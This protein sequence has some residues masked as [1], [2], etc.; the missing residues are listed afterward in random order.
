MV[1][2]IRFDEEKNQLLK[3]MGGISFDD[4]VDVLERKQL[5]DDIAHPNKKYPRQRM[6]VIAFN[7]YVYAVP[8]VL[9]EQKQEIF[10]KTIYASRVLSKKYL[11]G[12]KV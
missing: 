9:D 10:L 5:L 2:S 3:A 7:N 4:V 11:K 8:Y 1:L 6:Y 12:G